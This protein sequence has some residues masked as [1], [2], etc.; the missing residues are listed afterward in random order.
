MER[1]D[2]TNVSKI[3]YLK[4]LVIPKVR[5]LVDG[6]PFNTE[7]YQRG[8]TILKTKFGKLRGPVN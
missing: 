7:E 4:D 8:K 6:F 5:A 1:A 3:S 2:I